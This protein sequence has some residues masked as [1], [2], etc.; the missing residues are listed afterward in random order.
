MIH[1]T[2]LDKLGEPYNPCDEHT[3]TLDNQIA[4]DI[5]ARESD[6]NRVLCFNLCVLYFIEKECNCSLE[7]QLWTRG[8]DT[9]LTNCVLGLLDSFDYNRNCK[10]CPV[11]CDTVLYELQ[12]S[13][14]PLNDYTYFL[15]ILKEEFD[16]KK[17]FSNYTFE[18]LN[19]KLILINIKFWL[20]Q[21]IDVI[22]M[23]KTS[24][25]QLFGDLGGFIGNFK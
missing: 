1:K 4:R 10:M 9:C 24:L 13:T 15:N 21:S 22:E 16:K 19:K 17:N 25:L 5:A 6:Y 20:P 11:K 3:D 12:L 2:K 18:Q 8:N 14:Q 7:Y 23:P